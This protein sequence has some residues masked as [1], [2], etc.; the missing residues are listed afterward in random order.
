MRGGSSRGS[1]QPTGR[2]PDERAPSS[3]III[4]QHCPFSFEC[5]ATSGGGVL[6]L[7]RQDRRHTSG[8]NLLAPQAVGAAIRRGR[9]LYLASSSLSS[10]LFSSDKTSFTVPWLASLTRVKFHYCCCCSP[11]AAMV[12]AAA[13]AAAAFSI[14]IW[15]ASGRLGSARLCSSTRNGTSTIPRISWRLT[16]VWTHQ[17]GERI[18]SFSILSLSPL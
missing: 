9:P 11:M 2:P 1:G 3:I 13:A 10:S 15:L 18:F 4:V 8:R 17:I 12:A 7:A 6:Q 16:S 5:A 14:C